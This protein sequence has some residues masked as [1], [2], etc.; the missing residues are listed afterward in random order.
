MIKNKR[1]A[2]G[3]SIGMILILIG[4]FTVPVQVKP[5]DDTRILLEHTH[6]TYIAPPC[7]E[8]AKTTNNLVETTLKEAKETNYKPESQCTEQALQSRKKVLIEVIAEKLSL[9][10]NKWDW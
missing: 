1:L 10:E 6:K 8:Q 5:Y 4:L 2:I 3:I 7:F 9:K